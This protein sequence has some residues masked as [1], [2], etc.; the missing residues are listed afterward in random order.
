VSIAERLRYARER[1]G[2]TLRQVAERTGIGESSLSE[3]ENGKREPRLSQLH[4]LAQVYRRSLAFLLGEGSIPREVVL[5][6]QRP[7]PAVVG[8]I[9]TTFLRFCEQYHNLEVWCGERSACALPKAEGSA[10]SFSYR[11][12]ERLAYRVQSELRLGDRPGRSLFH[13]LEEVCAVKLFHLSFQPTGPAASTVSAAF[14]PAILLNANNVR[15]RR[16]FDLA[17]ELFHVLTWDIFRTETESTSAS[18]REEKLATCFASHLLMPTDATRVAIN[19][20]VTGDAISFTDLS[21]VARQ[22]DVSVDALL[23]RIHF[24]FRREEE[25]TRRDIERYNERARLFDERERDQPPTRPRRYVALAV[26]ALRNGEFSIGKFAEYL[27]ISRNEAL[28][29]AEQEAGDDE[30]VALPPA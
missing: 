10:E 2:L 3:F 26:K 1:T 11:E 20:A 13:V 21:A 29:F 25:D 18:E 15:W 30:E 24:L 23:W 12:A 7:E 8:E 4:A 9:E 19:D 14:G 5:W 28:R 16:N 22:F 27:G 6:R 17:H